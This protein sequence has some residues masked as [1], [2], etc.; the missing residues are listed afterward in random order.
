MRNRPGAM[1]GL[2][3]DSRFQHVCSWLKVYV[4]VESVKRF[5]GLFFSAVQ[6]GLKV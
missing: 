6:Q 4:L 1:V 2:Q 3:T 5:A